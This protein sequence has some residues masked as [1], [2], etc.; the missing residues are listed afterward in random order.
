M[1]A[2]D[3]TAQPFVPIRRER[4]DWIYSGLWAFT[5]A[6]LVLLIVLFFADLGAFQE[7]A[8]FAADTLQDAYFL[9]LGFYVVLKELRR[10]RRP[11]YPSRHRGE[12][13]VAMWFTLFVVATTL[14]VSV[15]GYG[16]SKAYQLI[17]NS[18][19][20]SLLVFL[21]SGWIRSQR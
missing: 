2:H 15:P 7:F 3:P 8:V 17:A 1:V 20:V 18:S 9:L 11:N 10:S 12:W 13:F 14:A 6:Y 16:L 5:H 21:G 4:V 19:L